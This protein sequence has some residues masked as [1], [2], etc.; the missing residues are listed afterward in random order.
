MIHWE[1][2]KGQ[3]S[4]SLGTMPPV[5]EPPQWTMSDAWRHLRGAYLAY[6]CTQSDSGAFANDN[7]VLRA[8][9]GVFDV[10]A[11]VEKLLPMF[12]NI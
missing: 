11:H 1:R 6:D 12:L 8:G 9:L 5:Y 4:S 3:R 7:D 10:F 2:R